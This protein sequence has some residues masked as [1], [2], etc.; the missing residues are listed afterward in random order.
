MG[1][2][3]WGFFF[4]YLN[5]NLSVNAHTLNVLPEFVGYFLLL[6]G[7]RELEEESGVF[8]DTRP[9]VVGMTVYTAI[10]WV[11]A[12]LGVTGTGNLLSILLSLV[13][14]AVSL[15][16]SWSI[17]Q[18]VREME[19]RHQADLNSAGMSLAWKVLL[20]ADIVSYVLTLVLPVAAAVA[21][22]VVLV[23]ILLLVGSL[24]L[25]VAFWRGKKC[26]EA[27]QAGTIHVKD[28]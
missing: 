9:F 3:F 27:V 20:V 22:V 13:S 26:W 28:E 15:Y 2:F 6:Q 11:G 5:F 18:G 14:T 19:E 21:L 4:I 16:I 17:I 7:L 25:L 23:G 10:L 1:K 12:L 24:M 8:S